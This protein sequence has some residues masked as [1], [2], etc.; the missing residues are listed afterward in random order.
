MLRAASATPQTRVLTCLVGVA[1]AL[2]AA[3]LLLPRITPFDVLSDPASPWVVLLDVRAEGSVHTWFN[4]AVLATGSALAVVLALLQRTRG[5]AG[6]PWAVVAA[7]LAALSVDDLLALHERMQDVGAALVGTGTVHF[8]WVVPG[9]LL[10][11]VLVLALSVA[12]SRLPVL[13][14]RNLLAGAV[15]LVLAAI[16]LEVAGGAV[17]DTVGDGPLYIVVSHVEEVLETVAAAVLLHGVLH[18]F[19][20]QRGQD[21]VVLVPVPPPLRQHGV[22]PAAAIVTEV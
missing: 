21:G 7:T 2:G 16:G 9:A 1:L 14:R 19:R 6:W 15:L 4:V 5:R 8:A 20:L 13:S 11:L 3:S 22:A 18:G 10:A 17:L 12:A